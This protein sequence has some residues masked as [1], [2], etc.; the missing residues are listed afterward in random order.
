M[1]RGAD[2]NRLS[3]AGLLVREAG[4]NSLHAIRRP[5]RGLAL[6]LA[7]TPARLL[8]APS[9]IR[10]ADPTI[11]ND[12]Y[13]GYFSFAGK[14]VNTHGQPPFSIETPS[15]EWEAALTGFGW[16]RHLRAADSPLAGA[17]ARAL[18]SDWLNIGE[19]RG[20][21]G[22][23]PRTVA[24]RLLAWLSHSRLILEGVDVN[25]Y[26][27]FMRSIAR[28]AAT[29]EF[30]LP[31]I[32]GVD[33]LLVLT[34]L[35]NIGLCV[36]GQERRLR[37]ASSWLGAEL[38]RQVLADGGHV[39]RN[40]QV[41]V[42][43]LLD[44]LPLR[45]SYA[46][47]GEAPPPQLMNAIDR[48]LPM[49]RLFQLGDGMLALFNGMSATAAHQLATILA[50]DDARAAPLSQ[51]PY[52]GY[53]RLNA[54]DAALVMDTGAPPPST[55]SR[56]AHAGCLSF[57]FVTQGQRLVVNCGAPPYRRS[58]SI[59]A[60][61]VTAA[62][63]TLVVADTSS[64]RFAPNAGPARRLAGIII[65]GPGQVIVA[66]ADDEAGGIIEASHDGYASIFG[67]IHAR[68][69]WLARDGARLTGSDRLAPLA[70]AT[71]A[72]QPYAIRFHAH[73]AS[74]LSPTVDGAVTIE[75]PDGARWLFHAT[76]PATI[77][78]SIAFANMDR[79][80]GAEQIV[81][82]ARSGNTPEVQ[83]TFERIGA[84]GA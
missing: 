2:A 32:S 13:A 83:W 62:H 11:A 56:D 46:A 36:E 38:A 57:E 52:S 55:F 73:P 33:R 3:L 42:D 70:G 49:L 21:A 74:T 22:W 29:L 75:L 41:I 4:R 1:T 69:I 17:Q 25:F 81:I 39:S 8:I 59:V 23:Q 47:R 80:R 48:M 84:A 77:E 18:V 82:H 35:A 20:G 16:L 7:R 26:R 61:R 43:L 71:L 19:R 68:R 37:R 30:E 34:A 54:L 28:Q 51:A 65:G 67:F 15:A 60:A 12:L 79:P 64:C 76:L 53:Q 40:P 24:R 78:E 63:S 44:L 45:Q 5:F 72:D 66:R 58:K 27:R 10:T 31:G 50:Y 9:D 14:V 6:S